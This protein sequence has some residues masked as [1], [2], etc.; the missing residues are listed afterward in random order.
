MSQAVMAKFRESY[1][2]LMHQREGHSFSMFGLEIA[3]GWYPLVFELFGLLDDL[4]RWSGQAISV[5]Q[6]KEKFGSLRVYMS[7]SGSIRRD[8]DLLESLFE[9]LSLR[10][11]DVCGAAGR[12]QPD[13]GYWCTRCVDHRNG[14]SHEVLRRASEEAQERFLVYERQGVDTSNIVHLEARQSASD[15]SL[16]CLVVSSFPDRLESL[17]GGLMEQLYI[18][19]LQERDPLFLASVVQELRDSGK[20]LFGFTD[21]SAVADVIMG[22][23]R[24][25]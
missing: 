22:N 18:Q 2:L 4:Q 8:V 10:I 20:A 19:S 23:P 9:R 25:D 1:P 12:R 15:E 3:P 13:D 16:G 17:K 21:A 7:G 5:S 6:V 24:D 14:E 11:C